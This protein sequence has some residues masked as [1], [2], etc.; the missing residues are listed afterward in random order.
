MR[1]EGRGQGR[2]GERDQWPVHLGKAAHLLEEVGQEVRR[3]W[4]DGT[5][6]EV[7]CGR[8]KGRIGK[9]GLQDQLP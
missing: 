5:G 6:V 9:E 7:G 1:K 2:V 4:G 8:L 3:R